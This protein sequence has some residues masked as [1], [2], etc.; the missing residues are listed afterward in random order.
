M[1]WMMIIC[2]RRNRES[3][4]PI[5]PDYNHIY[6]I[7]SAL[8]LAKLIV[9]PKLGKSGTDRGQAPMNMRELFENKVAMGRQ[10]Q[11]TV[12]F[13]WCGILFE[14]DPTILFS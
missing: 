6:L 10:N 8:K 3:P 11:G 12:P 14:K 4:F 2:L 9:K 1:K 13:G 5:V 7:R